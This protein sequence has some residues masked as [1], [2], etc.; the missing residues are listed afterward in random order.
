MCFLYFH[1]CDVSYLVRSS[2]K[3]FL[4]HCISSGIL[5]RKFFLWISRSNNLNSH[6]FRFGQRLLFIFQF[7][8]H[9]RFAEPHITNLGGS[10]Q[11]PWIIVINSV[12]TANRC[13]EEYAVKP[14]KMTVM[15]VGHKWNYME[16][17]LYVQ[18][19]PIETVLKI[20]LK[21]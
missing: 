14:H 5:L 6:N 16:I 9:P 18:Q 11:S 1:S 4:F 13:S 3:K 10:R 20:F 19:S 21:L 7:H 15:S 8:W 17:I 12:S 2:I